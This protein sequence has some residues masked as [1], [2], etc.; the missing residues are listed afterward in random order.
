MPR[1]GTG[2]FTLVTGNPVVTGTTISSTTHNNTNNDIAAALTQS[3]SSDG[4]T[5]WTGPTNLFT[6]STVPT[7]PFGANATSI[8]STEFVQRAIGNL[9]GEVIV[10]T[11]TT[12]TVAEVGK[13]IVGSTGSYTTTLPLANSVPAGSQVM[14]FG[15]EGIIS[16]TVQRQGTDTI[17]NNGGNTS[18]PLRVGDTAVLESNGSSL[19][20]VVG[21]SASLRNSSDFGSSKSTNGYQKLPS[22]IIIQWGSIST[23][24]TAPVTVTLPISFP[25]NPLSV[26]SSCIDVNA[27]VFSQATC[28]SLS[29]ISVSAWLNNGTRSTTPVSWV[30]IGY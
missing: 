1:N 23:S 3:I 10:T 21:G 30:A 12:L 24:A 26:V 8:A 29:T 18:I 20:R 22:G 15:A 4:Q 2:T 7:Q 28:P 9:R 16:W 25:N 14:F 27:P 19:W 6:G 11:S 17:D 5:P 13:L